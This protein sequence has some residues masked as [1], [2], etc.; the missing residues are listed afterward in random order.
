MVSN[1]ATPLH[2]TPARAINTARQLLSIS[3]R[4]ATTHI[5]KLVEAGLLL[6][7]PASGRVRRFIAREILAIVNGDAAAGTVPPRERR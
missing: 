1:S 2:S 7:I 4:A 6:E 3:H 5:T